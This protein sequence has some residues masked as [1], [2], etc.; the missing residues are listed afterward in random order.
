MTCEEDHEVRSFYNRKYYMNRREAVIAYQKQYAK[1]HRD[2]INEMQRERRR[3]KALGIEP[4]KRYQRPSTNYFEGKLPP[5]L[6][7]N[8][9]RLRDE[10]RAIPILERPVY[11]YFLR[12]KTIEYLK[13]YEREKRKYNH[14]A[15]I[16]PRELSD[17]ATRPVADT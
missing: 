5:T 14:P 4:E 11:D 13:N 15:I 2:H 16:A 8:R 12:C 1:D 9:M 10:Y 6:Y 7:M 17:T 3:R